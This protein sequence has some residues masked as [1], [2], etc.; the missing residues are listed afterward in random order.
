M[1]ASDHPS[2]APE[3]LVDAYVRGWFPMDEP[4]ARGPVGLFDADPR[5]I[6]PI[7][8]F[9]VPRTVAR[10]LRGAGFEIRVDAAFDQV[11]SACAV[12]PGEGTWL[13]PR[14]VAAYGRLHRRGLAHSVEAWRDGRLCGGLFG[15]ALGGLF[16]SETMFRRADDAGN[17]VLVATAR[18]LAERGF[19]LWDIQ[20]TSAHTERFGA[21]E[22]PRAEYRRRLREALALERRLT[23][24]G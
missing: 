17:A 12:R 8:A 1:R 18:L 20:M 4:G 21:V 3:A 9:R 22:V 10:R 13:T 16:S 24:P 7:E 11:A 15:V 5:G 6:M 19:V 14:L 2:L 23:P